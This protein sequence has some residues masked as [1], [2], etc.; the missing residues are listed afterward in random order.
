MTGVFGRIGSK[1]AEIAVTVS[2]LARHISG[3]MAEMPKTGKAGRNIFIKSYNRRPRN[4]QKRNKIIVQAAIR[5]AI[6]ASQI[7]V[8]QSQPTPRF[9]SGTPAIVGSGRPEIVGKK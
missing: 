1:F 3:I 9:P 8:I 6:G 7:A 2:E 4:K 5:S